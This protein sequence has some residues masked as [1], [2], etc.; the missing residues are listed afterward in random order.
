MHNSSNYEV[1]LDQRKLKTPG[2][3][4][5]YVKNEPLALAIAAEWDAQKEKIQQSTMHLV[6]GNKI[7]PEI[8]RFTYEYFLDSVM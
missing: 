4:T 6:I 3:N 7:Y 8:R 5:F 2:G 1:I